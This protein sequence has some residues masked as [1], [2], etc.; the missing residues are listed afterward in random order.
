M[1]GSVRKRGEKWSYY[2]TYK[3]DGKYEKKEKGGFATK[4]EAEAAL[5][6]ALHLYDKNNI[7][8]EFST[9]TLDDYINYRLETEGKKTLK[10]TTLSGYISVPNK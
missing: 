1:K 2:F 6:E 7:I 8:E 5:R 4:R 9:F 3:Q 10:P